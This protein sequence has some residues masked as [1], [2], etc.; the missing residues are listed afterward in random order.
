MP[1]PVEEMA[2]LTLLAASLARADGKRDLS[3]QLV[4]WVDRRSAES[5]KAVTVPALFSKGHQFVAGGRACVLALE[6][7]LAASNATS[8]GAKKA[9]A[10][11]NALI[12]LE[13][14]GLPTAQTRS[15]LQRLL[16]GWR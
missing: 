5:P 14:L 1:E 12:D 11:T 10:L 15:E 2:E 6:S 9:L 7:F 4:A 8:K 3:R 16:R 13:N